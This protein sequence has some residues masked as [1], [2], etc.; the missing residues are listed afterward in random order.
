MRHWDNEHHQNVISCP[1]PVSTQ[2]SEVRGQGLMLTFLQPKPDFYCSVFYDFEHS[3]I[4]R[5]W[6]NL[7]GNTSVVKSTYSILS[8]KSLWKFNELMSKTNF[9]SSAL[10]WRVSFHLSV[11][12][13]RSFLHLSFLIWYHLFFMTRGWFMAASAEN[14]HWVYTGLP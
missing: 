6:L 1:W 9:F 10:S 3:V 5:V 8:Q 11:Q 2:G 4:N 7:S 14:S 12:R 13:K